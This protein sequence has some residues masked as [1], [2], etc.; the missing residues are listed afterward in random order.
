MPK[1]YYQGHGSFRLTSDD[2]RV[3]YVDPFIGDGYDKPADFILVSHQHGDHNLIH[4]C[5]QKPGCRII[6]NAE[7]LEGGKH[8]SFD[9]GGILVEAVDAYNKNHDVN[10]CVGFI[11]SIDGVKLYASG[12]TSK[13]AQMESFPALNLDYAVLC[14]DGVYNMSPAE[15][16]ECARV[17]CAKHNI[18]VHNVFEELFSRDIAEK[19]DAPNKLIIE[20]GQEIDL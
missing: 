16:A 7:A 5:A 12:D 15:A 8:N 11:I 4:L 18:M 19:W 9:F 17:I 10:E 20:P 3:I 14:S 1:M 6:S 2:G 13:T